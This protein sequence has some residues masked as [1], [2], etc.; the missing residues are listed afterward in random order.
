MRLLPYRQRKE[1][2]RVDA[3][4]SLVGHRNAKNRMTPQTRHH[5]GLEG[6]IGGFS[7]FDSSQKSNSVIE[8]R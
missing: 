3:V 6:E 5:L 2:R 1:G 4:L 7:E 8:R